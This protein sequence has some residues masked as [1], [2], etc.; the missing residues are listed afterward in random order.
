M[1]TPD[2]TSP[3]SPARRRTASDDFAA[4]CALERD[5]RA[6]SDGGFDEPAFGRAVSLVLE[7]LRAHDAEDDR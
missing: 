3:E 5:R 7:R 1:S 2:D 6:N 4:Y